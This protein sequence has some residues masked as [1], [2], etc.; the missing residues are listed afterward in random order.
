MPKLQYLALGLLYWFLHNTNPE[1]AH[2]IL[3]DSKDQTDIV[4]YPH[5]K[6]YRDRKHS[7]YK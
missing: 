7:I 2:N 6:G 1:G 3:V 4:L 5:F